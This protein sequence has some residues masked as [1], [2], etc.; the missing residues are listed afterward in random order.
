MCR[1]L[2]VRGEPEAV[3]A[4][5][6]GHIPE[7]FQLRSRRHTAGWG[8][9]WYQDQ[10]PE[11]RRKPVWVKE[12]ST[13]LPV[14]RDL[15]PRTAILHVRRATRGRISEENTHPFTLGRWAFAHNGT[16]VHKV[17]DAAREWLHPITAGQTD[18][19]VFF[20]LLLH[21]IEEKGSVVEGTRAAVRWILNISESPRLNFVMSDGD[22]IYAYRRGHTLYHFAALIKDS[23]VEGVSSDALGE[24]WRTIGRDWMITLDGQPHHDKVDRIPVTE[25][26]LL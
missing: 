11:L 4:F 14:L 21:F 22:R 13:F 7:E 9:A 24:G 20:H 15:T 2:A 19:E 8:I 5:L 25:S 12:D 6:Q 1:F 26:I 16:I 23:P 18:S 17:I 3:H 10:T